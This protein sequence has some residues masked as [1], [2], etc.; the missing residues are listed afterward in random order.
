MFFFH[1]IL[2]NY[3]Y[4]KQI[5]HVLLLKRTLSQATPVSIGFTSVSSTS[6]RSKIL[7]EKGVSELNMY[8]LLDL[9]IVP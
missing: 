5:M 9:V 6:L 2:H 3:L 7:G 8:R 4:W 1:T